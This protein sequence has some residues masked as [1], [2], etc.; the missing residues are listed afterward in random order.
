MS[1]FESLRALPS[2]EIHMWE[3]I[4]VFTSAYL[5]SWPILAI[6]FLA[7]VLFEHTQS[8]GWAVFT[9]I[10]AMIVSYFYFDAS[11]VKILEAA[12]VYVIVGVVWS[13][14][15]YHQHVKISAEKLRVKKANRP[16]PEQPYFDM[17]IRQEIRD[18]APS[19]NLDLITIWIII[20]PFS[21]V[22][23]ILSDVLSAIETLVTR[24][25]KGVYARIYTSHVSS[26]LDE[27]TE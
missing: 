14:W 16:V 4:A 11:L 12:V 3:A 10:L 21:V 27:V 8:R 7:G 26:L 25:F 15:R 6:L 23:N 17:H 13:F 9:G 24:V 19:A 2:G 1:I 20:W 18:L 5:L 22:E